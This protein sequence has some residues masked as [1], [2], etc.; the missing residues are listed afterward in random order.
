MLVCAISLCDPGGA[1]CVLF[2]DG[3]DSRLDVSMSALETGM[4]SGFA[5]MDRKVGQLIDRA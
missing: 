3:N 4:R 2:G 5:R 1:R